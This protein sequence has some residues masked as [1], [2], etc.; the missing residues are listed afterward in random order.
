MPKS[1]GQIHT[2][3]YPDIRMDQTNNRLLF[4][5]PGQLSRQLQHMVR[6]MSSFKLVGVDISIED[7]S[8]NAGIGGTYGLVDG[9]LNYFAP[10]KGRVEALKHAYK[11]TRAAMKLKGIDPS[12]NINYDFRPQL[13]KDSNYAS[14]IAPVWPEPAPTAAG[15]KNKASLEVIGGLSEELC[16]V[17]GPPGAASIF[18]TWN[19]GIQPAMGGSAPDFSEGYNIMQTPV[20][21]DYVINEE[22]Y[23]ESLSGYANPEMESI[24]VQVGWGAASSGSR[25]AASEF[26]WRPDP[27]LYLAV[28][29]GQIEFIADN[30]KT[31]D[32]AGEVQVSFAFHVAG[33]KGILG[34]HKKRRHSKRK[35]HGR[36][37]RRTKR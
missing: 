3:N 16:L 9:S 31:D 24:P 10:T 37:R 23:I 4:D 1:L 8:P 33:W 25:V 29:T 7:Y 21:Q 35:S 12:K 34:D 22:E 32:A 2:V 26:Q 6:M 17:D 19:N 14:T 13:S 20:N 11:A 15:F 18:E 36:K 5:L 28:L 30:V 27:A